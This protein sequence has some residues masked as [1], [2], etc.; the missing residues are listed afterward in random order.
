MENGMAYYS[1]YMVPIKKADLAAYRETFRETAAIFKELG[2]L[3]ITEF[4]AADPDPSQTPSFLEAFQCAPDETL[5]FGWA[6]WPSKEVLDQCNAELQKNP[7]P[8]PSPTN[9]DVARLIAGN[10]L[11][12]K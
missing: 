8:I 4:M 2:A 3:E 10:F 6:V 11:I 9:F 7:R 5:V 1:C 12:N